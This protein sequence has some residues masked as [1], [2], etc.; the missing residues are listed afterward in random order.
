MIAA[1]NGLAM[2]GGFEIALACDLII[3]ADNAA[4]ALPEPK[5]GLAALA[6]G[7][8]RLPQQIGLKQAMHIVLT[9]RQVSAQEGMTMGFVNQVTSADQLLVEAKRCAGEIMVN[10]PMSIRA[11]M[12]IV[13]KGRDE[14]SLAEA[15]A[16]Q[17]SYPALRALYSSEDVREGPLAFAEKRAPRWKNA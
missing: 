9:G 16:N 5:V 10:S 11:S 12:E 6:G 3:A 17:R 15:Y 1:V 13:R 7:L 14:A 8:L 4:F 2:G